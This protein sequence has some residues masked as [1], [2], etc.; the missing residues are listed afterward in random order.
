MLHDCCAVVNNEEKRGETPGEK[1]GITVL[2]GLEEG[3]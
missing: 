2:H 3:T 1:L